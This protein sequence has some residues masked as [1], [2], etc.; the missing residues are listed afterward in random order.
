MEIYLH[1]LRLRR[2]CWLRTKVEI[3]GSVKS[4]LDEVCV[5]ILLAGWGEKSPELGRG[6]VG[7]DVGRRRSGE[8]FWGV[9]NGCGNCSCS[10]SSTILYGVII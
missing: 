7:R 8:E 1:T 9:S 5:I 10:S 3:G 6:D 2:L 4:G